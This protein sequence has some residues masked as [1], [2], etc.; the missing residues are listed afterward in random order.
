M[1]ASP[2]PPPTV[3]RENSRALRPFSIVTEVIYDNA[4]G[5]ARGVRIVDAETNQ[6][7]EYFAK[8]IFP[9]KREDR[10]NIKAGALHH[11]RIG[12]DELKA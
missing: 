9:L 11:E 10:R 1:H 5:R 8:V 7:T 4:T 6:S 3:Q 2:T 12:I